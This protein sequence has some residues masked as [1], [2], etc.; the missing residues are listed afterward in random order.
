MAIVRTS[1]NLTTFLC[2]DRLQA[3]AEILI[4]GAVRPEV[5]G[6]A[7]GMEDIRSRNST[8]IVPCEAVRRFAHRR[9]RIVGI[10][11]VGRD[12]DLGHIAD[13]AMVGIH[14]VIHVIGFAPVVVRA[15]LALAVDGLKVHERHRQLADLHADLRRLGAVV[16]VSD[17]DSR[18]HRA[19]AGA[20]HER[21]AV[22]VA[23][24]LIR[25]AGR[26]GL[27][28]PFEVTGLIGD[29]HTVTLGDKAE[30]GCRAKVQ[31]G[32]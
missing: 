8:V 3:T 18:V 10:R 31:R 19:A 16:C 5:I 30:I 25:H 17:R 23:D 4:H 29:V 12:R 13:V 22:H 7:I 14:A 27:D 15:G 11:A 32:R 21:V 1:A 9:R 20:G 6:V 26:L 28:R 2:R 24:V